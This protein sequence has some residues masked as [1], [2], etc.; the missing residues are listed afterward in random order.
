MKIAMFLDIDFV[1]D[2]R[3]ENEARELARAGFEVYLFTLAYRLQEDLIED[4]G[5]MKVYRYAMPRLVYKLSALA[6]TLPV[7]HWLVGKKI[8]QFLQAVQADSLHIHDM[9]I[10]RAVF[11]VAGGQGLPITLDLHENRPAIMAF[12]PHLQKWTGKLLISLQHWHKKQMELAR[13]ADHLVLVAEEAYR[14]YSSV[15]QEHEVSILPNTTPLAQLQPLTALPEL[16]EQYKDRFIIFYMG[17]TGTRRGIQELIKAVS[18]LKREIPSILAIIVGKSSEDPQHQALITAS[19]AEEQVLM[20]GWLPPAEFNQYLALSH[21]CVSPLHRNLHH[22][23]TFANK[24]FLYMSQGK[25]QVVSDCPPQKRVVETTGCGLSFEA[26]NEVAFAER[27]NTLYRD[28]T[29]RR[30]MGEAGK[31]AVRSTYHFEE[32][33]RPMLQYYQ[34]L[35]EALQ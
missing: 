2:P 4:L 9:V 18:L 11:D 16:T 19:E 14:Y 21:V 15:K 8:R 20:T 24:I 25:A 17:D 35:R 3:V 6:Y 1:V 22:D 27:L 34:Q 29:L 28:E 7:Y 30:E 23:T 26:G 33:A 31:E 32:S 5:Y 12:Y 10:A 13:R